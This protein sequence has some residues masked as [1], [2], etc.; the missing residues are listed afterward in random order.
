MN[1][2]ESA[3]ESKKPAALDVFAV[4]QFR[5]LFFGNVAFFFAMQGQMLTR[6][7]LAWELTG[8]ATSL[9][10][11]NL[12]VAFPL[13]FASVLGGA[14]TDRVERRQLVI[15]GQTLITANEVFIL[16]LLL[17]GKL[18]FW[19]MLCTAFVAGCAFP[20]IMPAR[21]AITMKVVGSQ[22]LQSAMGFQSG[23][24]N[25]NRILGPAVMGLIVAQFSYE[26][27]Y[28]LSTALYSLAIVCMFGVDRSRSD[29]SGAK[30]KP[31]LEDIA[32]GFSY[33]RANRPVLICLLFGLLPMFLAMPFQNILVMLAEQAWNVSE[34][35][36]G[37]MMATGGAGGVV[38]ALWVVKR[39]D[40]AG[41][42]KMMLGSTIAFGVCLA[43]FVLTPVF[44]IALFPLLAANVF[45]NASQT[46]NNAAIQLLVEDRMRGRM[47][48]FMMLSFGLTP[49]GVFPMAVVADKFGAVSAILGA[50]ALL[51]AITIVFFLL[52]KTL[53][54]LDRSIDGVMLA[55]TA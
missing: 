32:L 15:F 9:A 2:S 23:A 4:T 1:T 33:I 36:V 28:Y 55:R 21:M 22:R 6:T 52:S 38:G 11:I 18:E 5:W 29:E 19:H 42:M 3:P 35:G 47:S 37:T 13:I 31:L 54:A 30:K 50:S 27:A 24:M 17:L 41:R 7:L 25:L 8:E 26:A 43:I 39:G 45:A 49:I 16:I 40:N 12:V 34:S 46:V 51:I 44:T 10:Y 48:S 14:I 53:R 20:F